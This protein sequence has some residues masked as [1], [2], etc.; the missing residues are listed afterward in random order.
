MRESGELVK[1]IG[2]RPGSLGWLRMVRKVGVAVIGGTVVALGLALIVLPGP[3]VV[4]VPFGIA[5]LGTEFGWAERLHQ[6]LRKLATRV[7]QRV[8]RPAN[9]DSAPFVS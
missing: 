1:V 4:V 3:A 9:A 5:I 6:R 8:K 7:L 2:K